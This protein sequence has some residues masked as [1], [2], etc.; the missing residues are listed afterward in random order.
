MAIKDVHYERGAALYNAKRYAEACDCFREHLAVNPKD[1]FGWGMLALSLSM[2][3]QYEQAA[4]IAR[5]AVEASP[6]EPFAYYVLASIFMWQKDAKNCETTIR[7]AIRLNPDN[8]EYY[9]VLASALMACNKEKEAIETAEQ[10]LALDPENMVCHNIRSFSLMELGERDKA[11]DSIYGALQVDPDDTFSHESKGFWYLK[12]GENEKAAEAFLEA[13]RLNP[14]A[15]RARKGL[16]TTYR[17]RHKYISWLI[18]PVEVLSTIHQSNLSHALCL[19]PPLRVF[20]ILTGLIGITFTG[21]SCLLMRWDPVIKRHM[22]GEEIFEIDVFT[23]L[24]L[25]CIVTASA[26]HATGCGAVAMPV[27]F[28]V[29]LFAILPTKSA[30]S[31]HGLFRKIMVGFG[32]LI[33]MVGVGATAAIAFGPTPD[34]LSVDAAILLVIYFVSCIVSAI[35][36]HALAQVRGRNNMQA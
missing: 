4:P 32:T 20:L 3:D 27:T 31:L 15:S 25:L 1:P 22:D 34:K 35:I 24:A 8:A 16:I 9:G 12:E 19:I 26:V 18:G 5:E 30:L 2:M 7:E 28:F 21:I 6:N 11:F 14:N 13:L 10:G 33:L 36:A 17:R 23:V 29:F